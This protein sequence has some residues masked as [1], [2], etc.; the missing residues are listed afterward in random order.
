MYFG[1]KSAEEIQF[2]AWD[3]RATDEAAGAKGKLTNLVFVKP[4]WP[5]LSGEGM[6]ACWLDA[7]TNPRGYGNEFNWFDPTR[8]AYLTNVTYDLVKKGFHDVDGQDVG[9]LAA[10]RATE[11]VVGLASDGKPLAG[12]YVFITK[13]GEELMGDEGVMTDAAGTAWFTPDEPGEY[14]AWAMVDGKRMS[15]EVR[16]QSSELTAKAGYAHVTWVDLTPGATEKIKAEMAQA[17]VVET[18]K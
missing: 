9:K 18:R 16:V 11:V 10:K 1:P 6:K 7:S 8:P 5:S 15:S 17:A 13:K 2:G 4:R 12:A 14:E 3:V